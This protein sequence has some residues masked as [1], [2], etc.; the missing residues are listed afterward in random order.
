[1]A[2]RL[3][4]EGRIR[5]EL[6]QDELRIICNFQNE[7]CNGV[8]LGDEFEAR[9]GS[10]VDTSRNLLARLSAFRKPEIIQPSESPSNRE[11]IP[12]LGYVRVFYHT[13][14]FQPFYRPIRLDDH[15]LRFVV[16]NTSIKEKGWLLRRSGAQSMRLN[17]CN[18]IALRRA[19]GNRPAKVHGG[20][21]NC[22]VEEA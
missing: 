2:D 3:A 21:L 6:S 18:N 12:K 17:S 1:M 5:I 10:T 7:V 20:L 13:R 9:I 11:V 14:D 4:I 19:L 15:C 8:G 22:V 16:S